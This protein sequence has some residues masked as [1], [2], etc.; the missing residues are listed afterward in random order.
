MIYFRLTI[1][2]QMHYIPVAKDLL[3]VILFNAL[4]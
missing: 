3:M 2:C 1:I 4:T